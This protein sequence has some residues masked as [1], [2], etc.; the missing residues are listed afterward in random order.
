[1]EVMLAERGKPN[2][3]HPPGADPPSLAVPVPAP[4]VMA[5]VRLAADPVRYAAL[6][7]QV[8]ESGLSTPAIARAFGVPP[9]SLYRHFAEEGCL[10]MSYV[11]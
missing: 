3:V 5:M 8:E 11:V 7:R 6:R 2:G 10:W 4:R 1:M 9:T